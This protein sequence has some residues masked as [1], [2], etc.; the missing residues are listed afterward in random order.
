MNL[1]DNYTPSNYIP[2][3]FQYYDAAARSQEQE[4]QRNRS[5]LEAIEDRLAALPTRTVDVAG[6]NAIINKFFNESNALMTK[7]PK[8]TPGMENEI[9]R[10]ARRT[11]ASPEIKGLTD[12]YGLEQE[13][14]KMRDQL[15]AQGKV[16][17]YNRD[18]FDKPFLDASGK[19]SW[20]NY[21][22][23]RPGFELTQDYIG[24]A[25]KAIHPHIQAK[26]RDLG[27][28]VVN[29]PVRKL[30][31]TMG[32]IPKI[33][34]GKGQ[35]LDPNSK[36][37]D[38][39][40]DEILPSFMSESAGDQYFRR[41]GMDFMNNPRANYA[42]FANSINPNTQ[43]PYTPEEVA[44]AYG[45]DK[46]KEL[47]RS[48]IP[49]ISN[50]MAG[51]EDVPASWLKLLNGKSQLSVLSQTMTESY[52]PT[53]AGQEYSPGPAIEM[54]S[55]PVTTTSY[56]DLGK[57]E[58]GDLY[59]RS[60]GE[61]QKYLD[62]PWQQL[63]GMAGGFGSKNP[64][65]KTGRPM[66]YNEWIEDKGANPDN[67]YGDILY[68]YLQDNRDVAQ[69]ILVGTKVAAANPAL[70][71]YASK[72]GVNA[73]N[74][75]NAVVFGEK[76]NMLPIGQALNGGDVTNYK[77]EFT[78]QTALVPTVHGGEE[79]MLLYNVYVNEDEF[80]K[81]GFEKDNVGGADRRER[82]NEDGKKETLYP[83]KVGVSPSQVMSWQG[84]R[85]NDFEMMGPD[86]E[87]SP[88]EDYAAS[89]NFNENW[90]KF[91]KY[92]YDIR[93]NKDGTYNVSDKHN[94]NSD[95]IIIPEAD[96][97]TPNTFEKVYNHHNKR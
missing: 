29:I 84:A 47:L 24:E 86:K 64:Q 93:Q 94:K 27:W 11:A 70:A 21:Q 1:Y 59:E 16:W 42:G 44:S 43:Q 35:F 51:Y 17:E 79:P 6:K 91:K 69:K 46:A 20:Q 8:Y 60:R 81:A 74:N 89:W 80:K 92:G 85:A 61:Y 63:P 68:D 87:I 38:K 31:G 39:I 57:R 82:V 90:R 76:F 49:F 33:Q 45:R 22:D 30:D 28:K 88:E 23:T 9:R 56:K 14:R 66:S 55:R 75:S 54:P 26:M 18:V 32:Y 15:A 78:G 19:I 37:V 50:T 40:L 67:P 96:M 53:A 5:S 95:I 34:T 62:S 41:S 83:I 65:K 71:N 36:E 97:A 73:L 52:N 7:Y 58:R 25:D 4:Y 3:P 10:L 72:Q 12:L 48:R 77:K 2:I 13:H